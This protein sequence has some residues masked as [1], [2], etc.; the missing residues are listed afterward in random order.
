MGIMDTA[1]M[2]NKARKAKK[3]ME[4]VEAAGK[5]GSL[6]VLM[7][8]LY[9]ISDVDVN[10]DELAAELDNAVSDDELRKIKKLI[11]N[12]V[13]NAMKDAKKSLEKELASMTSLDDLKGLLG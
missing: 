11:E 3:Q 12:N 4:Q 10:M 9:E 8:G 7:N 1:K 6:A 5:A 2:V 13:K